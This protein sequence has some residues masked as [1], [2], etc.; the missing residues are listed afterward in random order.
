M[1]ANLTL[2]EKESGARDSVASMR[3]QQ[4]VIASGFGEGIGI[5]QAFSKEASIKK[6]GKFRLRRRGDSGGLPP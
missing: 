1:Q 4:D 2:S 3:V 5:S 6:Q